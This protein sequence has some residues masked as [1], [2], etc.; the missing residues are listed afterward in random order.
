MTPNRVKQLWFCQGFNGRGT[1]A[2]AWGHGLLY[3]VNGKAGMS[4]RSS[5]VERAT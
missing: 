1:P 4:T 3:V 5:R 2:P